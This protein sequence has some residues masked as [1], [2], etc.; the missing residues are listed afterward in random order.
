LDDGLIYGAAD[1]APWPEGE[2]MQH[3]RGTPK[4]SG[5][6]AQDRA[7]PPDAQ[8][9]ILLENYYPT[10]ICQVIIGGLVE[11]LRLPPLRRELEQ[12]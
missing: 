6:A 1:L 3:V 9:R 4:P 12:S 5:D 2:G 11:A 7:L 8:E 10:V